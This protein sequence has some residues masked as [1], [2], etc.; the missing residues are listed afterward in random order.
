MNHLMSNISTIDIGYQV[1]YS[2]NYVFIFVLFTI[3][4]LLEKHTLIFPGISKKISS[5]SDALE[6][7]I[8]YEITSHTICIKLNFI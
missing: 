4:F 7:A 2:I 5:E 3:I 8:L 1:D 6:M